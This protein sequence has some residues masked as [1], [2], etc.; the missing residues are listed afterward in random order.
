M[1]DRRRAGEGKK[2]KTG[3]PIKKRGGGGGKRS[4]GAASYET[5][6]S[7]LNTRLFIRRVAKVRRSHHMK[8]EGKWQ[9]SKTEEG[10]ENPESRI[11]NR[12]GMKKKA[13]MRLPR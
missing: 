6:S 1:L 13:A 5:G 10:G 3:E 4:G 9:G 2:E 8:K 11:M 12:V 7:G